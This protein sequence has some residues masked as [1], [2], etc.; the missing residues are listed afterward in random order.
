MNRYECNVTS[1]YVYPKKKDTG[2][3]ST[4]ERCKMA[5]SVFHVRKNL[6]TLASSFDNEQQRVAVIYFRMTFARTVN[7]TCTYDTQCSIIRLVE[8][9]GRQAKRAEC[10][11]TSF[12]LNSWLFV[13][14]CLCKRK[15]R[16]K[17]WNRRKWLFHWLIIGSWK[18][19]RD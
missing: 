13:Q 6:S 9:I 7:I 10:S 18:E 2:R 14:H 8:S 12:L 1:S 19:T 15:R 11:P 3:F 16:R 17:I 4:A 5:G